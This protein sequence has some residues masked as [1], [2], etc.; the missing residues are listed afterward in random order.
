[1][2]EGCVDTAISV[3]RSTGGSAFLRARGEVNHIFTYSWW[4]S[5]LERPLA[6]VTL[7]I[8]SPL[9][10]LIAIVIRLDSPGNPIFCQE[11]VGKGGRKFTSYKFRTMHANNDDRE[12]QTYIRKYIT[13][14]AAY[15]VDENGQRVYKVINDSRITR[16]GAWL[17]KTNLDEL[18]QIVNVLKGEMSFIGPRPEVSFALEMYSQWH[19]ERLSVAPGISGLWQV[20]QRKSLSFDD[21]VRLDID[22]VRRQSLLLDA[23]ILLLTVRTVLRGD[24]S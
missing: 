7:L 17:R 23:K 3:E 21:M 8:L 22:Y 9:F 2:A 24:G 10:A 5:I 6:L 15:Q 20:S 12:Y 13:E 18:P 11:R 1:V 14:N 16:F 19:W 4:K